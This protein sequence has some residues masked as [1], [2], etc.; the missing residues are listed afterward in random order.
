[1]RAMISVTQPTESSAPRFLPHREGD[2]VLQMGLARIAPDDW[3]S[4]EGD[5]AQWR[6][7]KLALGRRD[8]SAVYGDSAM[9]PQAVEELRGMLAGYLTSRYP[10]YFGH[11]ASVCPV[12]V[13]GEDEV[14]GEEPGEEPP[15]WRISTLIPDDIALMVPREGVYH[16]AAASLCSPS[17]WRLADKLG[18]P[19]REIHDP[20]PGVHEALSPR[21]DRF[22]RHL[23]VD[24]PVQRWN[25][26]LQFGDERFA[27]ARGSGGPDD[28]LY[29]RVERQSL[30]RLPDS[31]AIV[32]TIRVYLH[33]LSA[34]AHIPGALQTLLTAVRETPSALAAYKGFD[35]Y[36]PALEQALA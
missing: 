19:M 1:M 6:R 4:L 13:G 22:F 17:H 30:R 7:F 35:R 23:R 32:F 2:G 25:W 3:L 14:P 36:L 33:P 9:A 34:L 29:Y 31:G 12:P 24:A 27:P 26:S 10:Q 16:L 8:L 20:I 28:G 11:G 15:L 18:R 5:L 21:I